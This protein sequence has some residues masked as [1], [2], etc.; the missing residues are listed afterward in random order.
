MTAAAKTGTT[1]KPA[2]MG[3]PMSGPAPLP[4]M[5]DTPEAGFIP[6]PRL[7]QQELSVDAVLCACGRMQAL[8]V[9][10]Q[11]DGQDMKQGFT[12]SHEILINALWLLDGQVEQLR[13]LAEAAAGV[14]RKERA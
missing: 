5:P 13:M 9:L 1:G 2:D 6:D 3:I 11:A 4:F 12:V 14:R 7:Y 10:L 8:L